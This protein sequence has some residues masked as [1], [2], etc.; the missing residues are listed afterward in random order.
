MAAPLSTVLVWA[1]PAQVIIISALGAGATPLEVALA[2]GLSGV[3]FLPMVMSLLPLIRGPQTRFRHL[4]L[5]AHLTAASLWIESFRLLLLVPR[6]RRLAFCNGLGC[7]FMVS[8]RRRHR[9]LPCGIAAKPAERSSPVS[10]PHVISG[11]KRAQ[12][13]RARGSARAWAGLGGRAAA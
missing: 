3:R 13:P 9:L 6:E 4:V 10:H 5:P 1:G 2:V 7:G 8:R 11:F 12:Q